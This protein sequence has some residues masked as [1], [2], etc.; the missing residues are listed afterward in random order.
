MNLV[1]SVRR[2]K[3]DIP[4]E[5]HARELAELG[6]D[7]VNMHHSDWTAGLVGLFHR[8]GCRPSPG[9][10]R[11]CVT[12]ASCWRWISTACTPTTSTAWSPTVGEWTI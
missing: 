11:R 12:C 3:I 2:R 9:T 8:F 1:H 5:R 4:L 6:I 10:R 7:V